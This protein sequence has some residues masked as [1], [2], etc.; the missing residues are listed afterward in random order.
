MYLSHS[1]N[2]RPSTDT[3]QIRI[4]VL[5]S[6]EHRLN[7]GKLHA[8]ASKKACLAILPRL[9]SIVEET[10]N[11][12]LKHVAL[13]CMDRVVERF[14]KKDVEA[15]IE[16]AHIVSSDSCLTGIESSI[17]TAA[18]LCLATMVEVSGDVFIPIIPHALEKGIESLEASIRADTE[19]ASLH[20]AVYSFVVALIIYLPWMIA[21]PDL[22]RLLSVSH[23]SANAEMGD[24]CDEMRVDA[25]RLIPKQV[26]AQ[27]CFSALDRTWTSAMTEGPLVCLIMREQRIIPRFA[28]LV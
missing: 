26:E 27:E 15:V 13:A 17:R 12:S 9:T 7:S 16:A 3:Y 8:Q 11:I 19:D 2:I 25:L 4:Q 22:D 18:F 6:F 5:R 14:G 23:E 10:Y 21:G 20:N 24:E 28:D 1:K